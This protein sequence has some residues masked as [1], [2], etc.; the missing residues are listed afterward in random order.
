MLLR[1]A[2]ASPR[3]SRFV[4]SA[5]APSLCA[6]RAAAAASSSSSS[7]RSDAAADAAAADAAGAAGAAGASA[8]DSFRA[9]TA[10]V[11]ANV[12]AGGAALR[13]R[14]GGEHADKR[15]MMDY[16]RHREHK[17]IVPAAALMLADGKVAALPSLASK[18]ALFFALALRGAPA[19][20]AK[21]SLAALPFVVRD[22][23]MLFAILRHAQ[24]PAAKEL[25]ARLAFGA[26]RAED[27]VRGAARGDDSQTRRMRQC[28][29]WRARCL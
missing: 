12:E 1:L 2:S 16:Y 9:L 22:Q 14:Y 5:R 6:L 26:R 4:A 17:F 24:L 10:A 19:D 20:A 7:S 28:T 29:R 23:G 27:Q 18:T 15:W 11:Q 3:L 25:G 13:A 8:G 21:A